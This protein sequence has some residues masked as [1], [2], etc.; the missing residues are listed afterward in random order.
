MQKMDNKIMQLSTQKMKKVCPLYAGP[1]NASL[2]NS[3]LEKLMPLRGS[4]KGPIR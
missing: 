4:I 3:V 2:F 1:L